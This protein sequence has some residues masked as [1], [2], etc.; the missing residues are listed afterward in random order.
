M[1]EVVHGLRAEIAFWFGRFTR[2]ELD[3]K[4]V[5][6]VVLDRTAKKGDSIVAGVGSDIA[7]DETNVASQR[8]H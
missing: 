6:G 1:V 8:G 5:F 3:L 2:I 7:A 4:W